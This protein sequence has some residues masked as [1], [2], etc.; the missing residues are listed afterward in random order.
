MSDAM[1]EKDEACKGCHYYYRSWSSHPCNECSVGFSGMQ[2]NHY[3]PA[4]YPQDR[5]VNKFTTTNITCD[6]DVTKVALDDVVK[7]PN[8]YQLCD[9]EAIDVIRKTITEEQF[10]GYI[11]GNV[12]KYRLRAGKK[13]DV[14]QDIRKALEYEEMYARYFD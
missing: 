14:Q 7:K 11:V 12:L 13:D 6:G 9:T 8:H 4:C 2:K 1:Y 10:K 5:G 3:S